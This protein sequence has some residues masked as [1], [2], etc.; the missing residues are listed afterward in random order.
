MSSTEA[1]IGVLLALF[2][3]ALAA[4]LWLGAARGRLGARAAA[5]EAELVAERREVA[6]AGEELR[7]VRERLSD[8]E[9]AR[10]AQSASVG[11]LRV[12]VA[13]LTQ[14]VGSL[15]RSHA[16]D[17]AHRD[18]VHG[19]ELDAMRESAAREQ[20]SLEEVYREK[21][22]GV[23]QSRRQIE[24]ALLDARASLQ[25]EFE[26]LAG[27]TLKSASTQFLEL[28]QQKLES[29]SALEQAS[30]EKRRSEI[31]SLVK[32]LAETLKKTDEKLD[33]IERE[34]LS[35]Y[36]GLR[37][38]LEQSAS[39]SAALLS[40]TGKLTR[41]LREP[42]VRGRYGEIQLRR[43]CELA[44]MSAYCDFAEQQQ[45]ID[46]DGNAL[47]P[48]MVVNLPN[49]RTI[50][51]DAKTNIQAYI[52]AINA[53]SQDEAERHLERFA[54]HVSDQATALGRKRY[55]AEHAGSPEFVVMFIPGDQ[56]IDAALSRRSD[57]LESAARQNVLLASPST[58][59]GLLRAVAVGYQEQR[60]ALAAEEL[61]KLGKELLD[62]MAT[63]IEH[64]V[65]VGRGLNSAVESYN[66]FVGS[67][68]ARLE[69]TLKKF[70]SSGVKGAKDL[71]ETLQIEVRPSAI[72]SA[73][74]PLLPGIDAGDRPPAAPGR[75]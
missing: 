3:I 7:S 58:L 13:E 64:A 33:A 60:L 9:R 38:Q 42:H 16:R 68:Q 54:R 55:W 31:D 11:E 67:Y 6:Q 46:S 36:S 30:H 73:L 43:V 23:E 4:A 12:T 20:R 18:E 49:K 28:A 63:A 15:E 10:D 29:R 35:A 8:S 69:P 61:R 5:L 75:S 17:L 71:P 25:R 34:R 40:E 74:S 27:Q 56:F 14:E 39:A 48:D 47:R 26:A 53:T 72:S 59:I 37:Q 19:Q 51:V 65:A 52:D 21:L 45:T 32:P 66:R 2:L 41:A 44:G 50:V 22:A 1:L 57:L 24:Q 62:R 70:E